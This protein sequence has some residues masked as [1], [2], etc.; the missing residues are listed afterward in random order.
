MRARLDACLLT[1]DE[2]AAG[3]SEWCSFT[4]PFPVWMRDAED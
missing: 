2:L 1:E 4:D 3:P